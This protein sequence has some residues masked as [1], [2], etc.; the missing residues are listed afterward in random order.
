MCC[1]RTSSLNASNPPIF[2]LSA[3]SVISTAFASIS[4]LP[5]VKIPEAELDE[6]FAV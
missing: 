4:G 6:S 3:L 2:P 1:G 5:T